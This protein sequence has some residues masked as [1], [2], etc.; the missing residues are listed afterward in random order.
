MKGSA[1]LKIFKKY[2][3]YFVLLIAAVV[4]GSVGYI[5]ES[6]KEAKEEIV[7]NEK[8]EVQ[9]P[10]E[11]KRPE[12]PAEETIG[13]TV[14]V[15]AT[16]QKEEVKALMYKKP[17]S[18]EPYL[19]FSGD[20]LVFSETMD[21]F[22]THAGADYACNSGEEIF[23]AAEGVVSDI[24]EDEYFGLTIE[25]EHPDGVLTKYCSLSETKVAVGDK[26]ES[27]SAIAI[28]GNTAAEESAM[29]IHLHFEAF[30][31]GKQIN[32]EELFK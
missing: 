3:I 18:G 12:T 22:R 5:T 6:Q 28:A 30:K 27:K 19:G 11:Q 13:K 21:D 2:S 9:K 24:Y 15:A 16:A 10:Q 31:E 29:G 8:I 32:P 17:V 23:A 4:L 1:A 7:R 25:I 20:N 26:V 14:E